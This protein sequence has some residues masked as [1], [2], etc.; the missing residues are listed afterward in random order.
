[1]LNNKRSRSRSKS[2]NIEI[3]ESHSPSKKAKID[4]QTESNKLNEDLI[5]K[6]FIYENFPKINCNI[7]DNEISKNVKFLCATCKDFIFCINCLVNEEPHDPKQKSTKYHDYYIVDKL[8]F[9]VFTSDWNA[10]EEL[11][12]LSGK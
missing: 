1:M 8:N 11:L 4:L 6:V 3:E 9:R 12:L 5:Q 7:C 10:S 2:N